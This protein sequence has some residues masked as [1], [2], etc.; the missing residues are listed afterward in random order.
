[1]QPGSSTSKHVPRQ[2]KCQKLIKNHEKHTET[3][4]YHIQIA[5]QHL[6]KIIKCQYST[7]SIQRNRYSNRF[8]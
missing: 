6:K 5:P 4:F 8:T 7:N 2:S 1:M 3:S